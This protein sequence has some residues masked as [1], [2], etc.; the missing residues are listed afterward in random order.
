MTSF[1][2]NLN[3]KEIQKI[4]DDG[5]KAMMFY[6]IPRTEVE[7]K[8]LRSLDKVMN[9]LHTVG[10]GCKESLI[11]TCNGYDDTSDEL[12]EIKEV[13]EFVQAIFKKYPHILYY[14]N[15]EFEAEKWMLH[16]IADEIETKFAGEK[17]SPIEY[18][19]R[20]IRMDEYPRVESHIKFYDGLYTV[21]KA[22]LKHG[23]MKRDVRGSKRMVID[24]AF[25]LDTSQLERL[26]ITQ[27]DLIDFMEYKEGNRD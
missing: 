11:I 23:K 4:I 13:R 24:Y 6:H 1:H 18:L 14:I 16:C 22:M 7:S 20:G 26:K 2:E 27:E 25:K 17:L 21:F 8:D 15:S 3:A 9:T 12:Y 10:K 5:E 19:E